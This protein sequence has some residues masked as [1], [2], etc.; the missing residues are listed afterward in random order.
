M[1]HFTYTSK[2]PITQ[3]TPIV[4]WSPLLVKKIEEDRRQSCMELSPQEEEDHFEMKQSLHGGKCYGLKGGE[5]RGV[6]NNYL[7]N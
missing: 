5:G 7:G 2:N 1:S 4:E 6:W 3:N